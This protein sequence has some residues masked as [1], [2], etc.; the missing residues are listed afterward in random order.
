M[1]FTLCRKK[2]IDAGI[3]FFPKNTKMDVWTCLV[4]GEFNKSARKIYLLEMEEG[5]L[6]VLVFGKSQKDAIKKSLSIVEE[7][8]KKSEFEVLD[9]EYN[10]ISNSEAEMFYQRKI[11]D[12]NMYIMNFLPN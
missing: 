9:I 5:E 2:L 1:E 11:S 8:T 6:S 7:L 4:E 3:C 12:Y 10:T